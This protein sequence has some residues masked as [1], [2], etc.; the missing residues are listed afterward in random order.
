MTIF[1]LGFMGCGKSYVGRALAQKIGYD[2]I[3]LDTAIEAA[4]DKKIVEIFNIKG[5]AAFRT[6]E[7]AM[8]HEIYKKN[9]IISTGGGTPCFA[10]NMNWMKS[11]GLTV[12][13]NPSIEIISERLKS[14]KSQR[15]LIS[16]VPDKELKN[17]IYKLYI[18]RLPYYEAAD[19]T[20]EA[21][22][23]EDILKVIIE[24]VGQIEL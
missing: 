14:E 10:D 13:L 6:I 2:F 21:E 18:Q 7:T 23:E 1:L 9:T 4:E 8:L 22:H 15:P 16:A 24:A 3:D 19:L 20:I 5:E 17:H 11:S 12:F